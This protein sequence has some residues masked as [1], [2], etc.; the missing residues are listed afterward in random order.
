MKYFLLV[1]FLQVPAYAVELTEAQAKIDIKEVVAKPI[2]TKADMN[3]A[4][5]A[6]KLL[7]GSWAKVDD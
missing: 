5:A 6:I 7:S 2:K 4:L 1:I 3:K